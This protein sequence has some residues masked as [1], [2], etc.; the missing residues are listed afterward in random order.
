MKF[1]CG[2]LL[3]FFLTAAQA[4]TPGAVV[5]HAFVVGKGVNV[6]GYTAVLCGAGQVAI[7]N[8]GAD[9]VCRTI[10]G[11][12]TLS[13]LGVFTLSTVNASVGTFGSATQCVT[14][15]NNAKGLTTAVSAATCTPP[16]G[17]IS[18][19]G[20]G[21]AA[22]LA[23]NV[24][25]SGGVI[26]LVPTRT[27]DVIYWNGST[28]T[29]LPGNN[30]GAQLLQE[31]ASG[32]PSWVA[33][34]VTIK[35][36]IFTAS[37]TYTPSAGMVAALIECQGSGAGGGGVAGAAGQSGGAG[38][39]GAGGYSR[40]LVNAAAVGGSQAVTVGNAGSGATAGNNN[41]T[42]GA[43]VSVGSLCTGKGGA[44]GSGVASGSAGTGG[45]G[46]VA[47]TGDIAPAGQGGFSGIGATIT[48][49]TSFGGA[50][51]SGFFGSG[52]IQT[53]AQ[54]AACFNGAAG[55]LYGSG[56]AGGAC[57]NATANASGGNGAKGVVYITEYNSQ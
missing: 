53:T 48:T 35:K 9:P 13:N 27:G 52:G 29:T 40:A 38:G 8:A 44:A 6:Q 11:D 31:N 54:T 30:T 42:A 55:N 10:S 57:Y 22:A 41:G 15:T 34:V 16:I 49:V 2:L 23:N 25:T 12:G 39:G 4:Q 17:S 5:N 47:G 33:G 7:G 28:Y 50:G 51:G 24:N 19:L 18:G 20:T 32:I 26:A 14:V 37:G 46:G 45:V 21:V 43:D 36:Q 1:L 56:G 3:S